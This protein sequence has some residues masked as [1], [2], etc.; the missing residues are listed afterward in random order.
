[1]NDK[2]YVQNEGWKR[3]RHT[4]L[5][6]DASTSEPVGTFGDLHQS[7]IHD[8]AQQKHLHP[9]L[10]IWEDGNMKLYLFGEAQDLPEPTSS[11]N[12]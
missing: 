8:H 1:M 10:E 4:H 2:Q 9:L 3:V 5:L 11:W 6:Q 12:I 7:L